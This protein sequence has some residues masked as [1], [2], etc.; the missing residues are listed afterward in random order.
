[1]HDQI[2]VWNTDTDLDVTS[3][4][5]RLRDLAGI[6]AVYRRIH[7][8]DLWGQDDPFGLAV[9]AHR[10]AL[11]GDTV[12]FEVPAY[13]NTYRFTLEPLQR[14]DGAV[15]GVAG[16][17][18]DVRLGLDP[19][20]RFGSFV[21]AE[22]QAG[23]GTWHIDLR[24][25]S[26]S[27]SD[28][29]AALLGI[30]H[31]ERA[32]DIRAFDHPEDREMVLRTI[33]REASDD[34]YACDHRI[35]CADSRVRSVRERVRTLFDERGMPIARLGTL[36]DITDL[37]EREAE[38]SDLAH[39]DALTHLPNRALLHERLRAALV[40]AQRHETHCAVVFIDLDGFKGINDRYGHETGDRVLV[41]IADRLQRYV[42]ASDTVA[43]LCG[44]EFVVV[45]EDLYTEEA[46]ADAALKLLRSFDE[47]IQ[48][49]DLELTIGASIG[50]SVAPGCGFE[51][52]HVLALADREMYGVKSRGG[53]NVAMVTHGE[54][55]PIAHTE[56]GT[57]STRS[58]QEPDRFATR[59]SA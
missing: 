42:R 57:C 18:H 11:A 20:A 32:F 51:A 15:V 22:R 36:I 45:L 30:D 41:R 59:R 31:N 21:D 39:F 8:S 28:G 24:T 17:A 27:L 58:S 48:V 55:T 2:L 13:G 7:V 6:G 5:A 44:D 47:P 49:G 1:M 3:L 4:T 23:L 12:S 16:R 46:A 43:R 53:H 54:E 52:G 26:T 56:K 25:G 37:K 40:R 19:R 33:G 9:V 34:G 29:L 50:V 38:L 10:W 35:L 14:A